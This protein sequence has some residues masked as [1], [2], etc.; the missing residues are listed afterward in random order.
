MRIARLLL[1]P[2]QGAAVLLDRKGNKD[3]SAILMSSNLSDLVVK[4]SE[5]SR[6]VK[7]CG[8]LSED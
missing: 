7:L 3:D 1:R 6:L 8:L 4:L 5:L 2:L